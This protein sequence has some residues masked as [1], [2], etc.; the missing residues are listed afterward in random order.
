[1]ATKAKTAA[2]A[3]LQ[4]AAG[5]E[6]GSGEQDAGAAF[7][8]PPS[9]RQDGA[10]TPGACDPKGPWVY[11]GPTDRKKQLKY[12][13]AWLAIPPGADAALFVP[14]AEFKG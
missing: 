6:T 13:T 12:K 5:Q 7:C 14:L 3:I 2:M 10:P 4:D 11:I 8:H 9:G 1:M